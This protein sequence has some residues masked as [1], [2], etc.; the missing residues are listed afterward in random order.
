MS[1]GQPLRHLRRQLFLAVM[2]KLTLLAVLYVFVVRA[3][4]P[5]PAD[6]DSAAAAV[7]GKTLPP[8][9]K[10]VEATR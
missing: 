8:Q 10:H 9:Q 6:A 4:D 2:V 7:V 3:I 5:P 1:E